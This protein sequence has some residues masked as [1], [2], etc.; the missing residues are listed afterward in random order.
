MTHDTKDWSGLFVAL[1]TPFRSDGQVDLDAFRRLVRHVVAGSA[2]G[3]IPLGTSGESPTIDDRER[4]AIITACLEEASGKLVC[5]GT[6]H[7]A[8]AKTAAQTKRAQQLGAHG[9]LV[10]TPYYNRPTPQGLVAHFRAVADA[11]KGLPIVAYNVPVRTGVNLTPAVL[12]DVF[13]IPQVVAIKESSGDLRQIGEIGRQLPDG[14]VLLAGD[15]PLALASIA[16]GAT[17]LVSV[18]GNV[19]PQAMHDL[20]AAARSG[21]LARAQ[22]LHAALS[23]L[24]N[25]LSLESN[26]IPLKAALHLRGLCGDHVRLPLTPASPATRKALEHAFELVPQYTTQA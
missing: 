15:D 14:K 1:A 25:A 21:D 5:V 10:V 26:P 20:V 4:D 17:G 9:A 23:P 7:N 8:T 6:G 18:L 13:A 16:V 2:D 3:L 19:L 24:M 12:S 22:E 11:A